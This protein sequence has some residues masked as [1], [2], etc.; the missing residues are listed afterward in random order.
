MRSIL[1]FAAMATLTVGCGYDSGT[2]ADYPSGIPATITVSAAT[3]D[4]L[5]SAGETRTLSAIVRD[6]NGTQLAEPALTWRTSAPTVATVN[7][8]GEN[9]TVTAVEDGTA[10]I[11]ASIGSLEGTQA[12]VVR[13]RIESIEISA[14]DSVVVAGTTMQLTVVGRDARQQPIAALPGVTFTSS[15]EFSILVSS[16]GLVTALFNPFQPQTSVLTATVTRDGRTV[17]ATKPVKVG[18]PAPPVFD[19]A[20]LL[21]TEA[22]RPDPVLGLGLGFSFLTLQPDRVQYKVLWS[23]LSGPPLVAHLHG[24][25][26]EDGVAPVLVALSL[27]SGH[28]VHGVATG[29]FT[30]ANILG[31]GGRP[32]ISLDSLVTLM[33]TPAVVYL[34]VHTARFAD[35]EVRG[36]IV[37]T[38]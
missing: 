27:G 33:R 28:D 5:V 25:D 4:P 20:A 9:A 36:G 3:T 26:T 30:A 2:G 38:R 12:V 10:V 35:G 7:G 8:S 1:T 34:D 13:R 16:D 15:N 11:T 29:S 22:V 18:S 24:P 31:T 37:A 23:S 32:A 6:R 14:P 17:S 19:F 21:L